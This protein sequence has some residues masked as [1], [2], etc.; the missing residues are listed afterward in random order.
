MQ[1]KGQVIDVFKLPAHA[2]DEGDLALGFDVY[3][4]RSSAHAIRLIRLE[5]GW[6]ESVDLT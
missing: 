4:V 5:I 3:I 1:F 2:F 6:I